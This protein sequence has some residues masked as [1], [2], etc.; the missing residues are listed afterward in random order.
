MDN[1]KTY[2]QMAEPVW[3]AGMETEKN[4]TLGFTCHFIRSELTDEAPLR[5][6]ITG[7]TIYRVFLNGKFLAHGPARA[8]HGYYRVDCLNLPE[9]LLAEENTLAVEAVGFN[10]NSF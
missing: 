4:M 7:S 8:A 10:V 6:C 9:E 2:F 5:L 3:A 1:S